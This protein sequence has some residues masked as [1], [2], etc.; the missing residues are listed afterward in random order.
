MK[1][2][3][4]APLLGLAKSI[5]LVMYT[6]SLKSNTQTLTITARYLLAVLLRLLYSVDWRAAYKLP[7]QCTKITKL[8]VFQFKLPHRRLSTNDFLNK[9][10][11]R[12]KDLCT[13][14]KTEPENLLHLFWS[15][16]ITNTFWQEVRKQL[17]AKRIPESFSLSSEK[18]LG[19]KPV[20]S[21]PKHQL[22]FTVLVARCF[23]WHCKTNERCTRIELFFQFIASFNA[24]K[25]KNTVYE[26]IKDTQEHKYRIVYLLFFFS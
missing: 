10:G 9:I 18:I 11:L 20:T 6:R 1:E 21:P 17:N 26:S 19:L 16:C 4:G 14:C 12:E 24:S 7:F 8:I 22:N 15:C 13:F 5:Y 2:R 3:C 23:I 25:P